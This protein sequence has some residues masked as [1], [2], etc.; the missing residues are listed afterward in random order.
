MRCGL[1]LRRGLDLIAVSLLLI[2][3]TPGVLMLTAATG[4]GNDLLVRLTL[5]VMLEHGLWLVGVR[6]ATE[7]AVTRPE[8]RGAARRARRATTVDACAAMLFVVLLGLTTYLA[9]ELLRGL[10]Y[11]SLL[12]ALVSRGVALWS[13]TGAIAAVLRALGVGRTA[14]GLR[15]LAALACGMAAV[16]V[17]GMA[18]VLDADGPARVV[19]AGSPWRGR[20]ELMMRGGLAALWCLALAAGGGCAIA[21]VRLN[22]R[23]GRVAA[24]LRSS[25][26]RRGGPSSA[27][28]GPELRSPVDTLSA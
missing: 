27:M 1:R 21:T 6:V 18:L 2:P 22:H 3:V 25:E 24:A 28:P 17:A 20:G 7:Y 10:L 23:F 8:T 9:T 14:V 4:S 13:G 11:A 26:P 15:V 5:L 16:S 19:A 12:V